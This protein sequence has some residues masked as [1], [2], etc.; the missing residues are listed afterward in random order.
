MGESHWFITLVAFLLMG[1]ILLAF[2]FW[3]LSNM[4][5]CVYAFF[6][7]LLRIFSKLCDVI[8]WL[9]SGLKRLA[10]LFRPGAAKNGEESEAPP[11]ARDNEASASPSCNASRP[12]WRARL[13][14]RRSSGPKSG[15]PPLPKA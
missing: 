8:I 15:K 5:I 2:V 13:P 6:Y 11:L 14:R 7:Y 12:V 10:S 4:L 9:L 3:G 1:M